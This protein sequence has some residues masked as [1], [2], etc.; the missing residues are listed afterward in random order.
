M[1]LIDQIKS[2]EDNVSKLVFKHSSNLPLE[3]SVIRKNDGKDILCIPSQTSCN[4]QCRHCHLTGLDIK[5]INLSSNEIT[6][7]II[8]SINIIKPENNT[9]LVSY[10]GA[11]EPL[12]NVSGIINSMLEIKQKSPYDNVRFGVSTIIPGKK[13]FQQFQEQVIKNNLPIKLHWSLH[14]TTDI[15]RK[16]LMP[17]AVDIK[18]GHNLVCNYLEKTNQ[19]IEIHY[20]LIKNVN[21]TDKDV[22]NIINLID[23]R[24]TFKILKFAE[25]KLEPELI[26]SDFTE[27]F[28]DKLKQ[29]GFNVEIYSPPGRSI[30][31]SC[32]MFIIDQYIK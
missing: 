28:A 3:V 6:E 1:Q 19:P 13:V 8:N 22:E 5:A 24:I 23:K 4:M 21:D 29:S 20:T 25:H 17:S 30:G 11:G 10:M 31:S 26:G 14:S 32:G 27:L 12:L 18:T 15:Q 2:Q 7:L 16:S 9:L